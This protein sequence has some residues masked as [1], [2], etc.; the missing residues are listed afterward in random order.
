MLD[1]KLLA[2]KI[3]FTLDNLEVSMFLMTMMMIGMSSVSYQLLP[4]RALK[5][6][7]WYGFEFPEDLIFF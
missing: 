6:L 5:E 3:Q 7:P 4:S 2:G 1:Y